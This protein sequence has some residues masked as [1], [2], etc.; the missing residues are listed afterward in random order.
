[1]ARK[2]EITVNNVLYTGDTA[3]ARDQ[4]EILNIISQNSLLPLM[5]KKVGDMTIAATLSTLNMGATQRLTELAIGKGGIIRST[6]TV[7]VAE[8]MFQDEIHLF[9]VLLGRVVEENIGPF[10]Q[11]KPEEK[12]GGNQ[13]TAN[14][15]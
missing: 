10:W 6:D 11:L 2:I 7:P 9:L 12:G 4:L 13:K 3:P 14:Q 15:R 1:M 5:D 8:N